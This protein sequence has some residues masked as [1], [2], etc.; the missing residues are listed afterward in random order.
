MIHHPRDGVRKQQ[1]G[2]SSSGSCNYS[3]SS[4]YSTRRW[5]RPILPWSKHIIG[6]STTSCS[7]GSTGKLAIADGC[8]A[9]SSGSTGKRSSIAIADER[10]AAGLCF[11]RAILD[12]KWKQVGII[13]TQT[14][15]HNNTQQH[16]T[17]QR[18]PPYYT[19]YNPPQAPAPN[20]RAGPPT[21]LVTN[22]IATLNS[23][24]GDPSSST[25]SNTATHP[26]PIAKHWR[27]PSWPAV[28]RNQHITKRKASPP[29]SSVEAYLRRSFGNLSWLAPPQRTPVDAEPAPSKAANTAPAHVAA[30]TAAP[31]AASPLFQHP[32]FRPLPCQIEAITRSY[33]AVGGIRRAPNKCRLP[34]PAAE[35]APS[36]AANTVDAAPTAEPAPSKAPA[37]SAAPT[38]DRLQAKQRLQSLQPMLQH[39]LPYWLQQ[40]LQHRLIRGGEL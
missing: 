31:T 21:T 16:K 7:T 27:P 22:T 5:V 26:P 34:E 36:K 15:T 33:E 39:R 28:S 14:T 19:H 40:R 1:S 37:H 6:S 29:T 23:L 17:I 35:P 32:L 10:T 18:N 30:R 12:R 4:S 3:C 8:T 9:A 11:L 2:H 20:D 25:R 38:A 24:L 13:R